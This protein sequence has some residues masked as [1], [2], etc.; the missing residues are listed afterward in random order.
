MYCSFALFK[1]MYI[2]TQASGVCCANAFEN[3]TSETF[4]QDF[5]TI[6]HLNVIADFL[7]PF[8]CLLSSVYTSLPI[9]PSACVCLSIESGRFV[10]VIATRCLLYRACVLWATFVMKFSVADHEYNT[11][12]S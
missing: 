1:N 5:A 7:Y 9:H 10:R 8:F 3:R 11:R 6:M 12:I 4:G 2:C